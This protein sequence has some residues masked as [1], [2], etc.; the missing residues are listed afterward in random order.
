MKLAGEILILILM[1]L[2]NG[3]VFS[4]KKSRTDPLVV[5]APLSFLLSSLMLFA[6]SVDSFSIAIF[7]LSILVVLSNFHALFRYTSHLV[8]DRYS[9]L[10]KVWAVFT[11]LISVLLLAGILFFRPVNVSNSK[12]GITETKENLSGSFASGFSTTENFELCNAYLSEFT[13]CPGLSYRSN[14]IIFMPDKRCD[15]EGY[16][17]YI[18]YL[19]KAGFT[20]CS[21]D[22]YTNDGKWIHSIEDTR[23][24]RPFGLKIRSFINTNDFLSRREFYTYNYTKEFEALLNILPERY[25]KDCKYFLVTDDLAFTAAEDIRKKYPDMITGTFNISSVKEFKTSGYGFAEQTNPLLAYILHHSRDKSL[26]AVINTVEQT[27]RE[28]KKA[29]NIK[30]N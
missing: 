15:T 14:V 29:W 22:F 3:R 5:L 30:G 19:S 26:T 6:F 23:M 18:Q 13:T 17:P 7:L 10:M 11:V 1:I 8:I 28:I 2:T 4:L 27:S 25:G 24:L 9:V 16:K 21:C 20:V 12:L